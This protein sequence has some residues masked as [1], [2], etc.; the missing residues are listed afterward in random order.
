M[1]VNII[2]S[3]GAAPYSGD[4]LVRGERIVSVGRKLAASELEGTR[5]VQGRG[6]TLMPGLCDAHTHFTWTNSGSLDGLSSMHVEEHT[7]FAA[8]SARTFL[9]CGYTSCVGAASAKQRLDTV[10]RNAINS[11]E[12]PGPRS[13]ANGKEMAPNDG[14]LVAG[15]TRFI[16]TEDEARAAVREYAEQGINLIKLSMSGEEITETLRAED[17]TIP[18]PIVAA[19]VETAHELGMRVCSHARSDESILQCLQYGVDIIYHAC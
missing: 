9:D 6:R 2:D 7:L 15:I 17:A 14:A 12:I 11:G 13:L 3:T 5:V 19:A 1:D 16:N 10:I 8:R 18:D 4:V